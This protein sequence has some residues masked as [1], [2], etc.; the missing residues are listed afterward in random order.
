MSTVGQILAAEVKEGLPQRKKDTHK[1][2]FGHVLVIGGDY[3]MAGA[4]R[5]AAEAAA[6]VGAG[7]VSVGSRPEHRDIVTAVRPELMCHAIS[8]QSELSSLI[9]KA[10]VMVL[11]PGLGQSDWSR[12]LC[13]T[14]VN[15]GLPMVVDADGLNWLSQH[16]S[17]K[18]NW[19][20]TPHPGE[21][22]RLLAAPN[23][24]VQTNRIKAVEQIQKKYGGVCVLKGCNTLVKGH[25]LGICHAGNPGMASGG[26]GDVL[27]GII[28]GLVAQSVSLEAAARVGVWLHATAADLAAKKWGERGLLALD[29]LPYVREL[30]N[31]R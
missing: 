12:M 30:I 14:A 15:V 9:N 25:Q 26:M 17:N 21:A 6:R 13:Q 22:A 1:G 27:S 7:L 20:L 5:L 23:Q 29:L 8:N 16:P 4:V 24:E 19:I 11:G 31:V 2:D 3:G 18:D 10:S 28:A